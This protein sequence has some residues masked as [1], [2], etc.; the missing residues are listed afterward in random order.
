[1]S[2]KDMPPEEAIAEL[3]KTDNLTRE[4]AIARYKSFVS[5]QDN[6]IPGTPVDEL[7][8]KYGSPKSP[9]SE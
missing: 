5:M 7:I 9:K 6:N 1:M 3:M 8:K 4:E 2:D